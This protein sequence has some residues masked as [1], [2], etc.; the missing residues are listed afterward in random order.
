MRVC[1]LQVA[2][3]VLSIVSQQSVEDAQK[4]ATR[5]KITNCHYFGGSTAAVLLQLA[6]KIECEKACVVMICSANRSTTCKH[7]SLIRWFACTR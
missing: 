1:W 5:N 6:N 2:G 4:N 3:E 7:I